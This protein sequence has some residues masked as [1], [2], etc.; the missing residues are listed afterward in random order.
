M[1]VRKPKSGALNQKVEGGMLT[2][3]SA[4]SERPNRSQEVAYQLHSSV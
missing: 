2:N 1:H 3:A 4:D